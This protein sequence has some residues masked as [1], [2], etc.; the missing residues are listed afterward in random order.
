MTP[1]DSPTPHDRIA[2][3]VR[4]ALKA[5]DRER[6]ATLRLLLNEIDNERIRAG[7]PVDEDSFLR[8]VRRSVKQRE[9]SASQYDQG[10]RPELA[11]RER[12]EIE[13]LSG[14]L[15]AELDD[16]EL[17]AAIRGIIEDEGLAGPAGLG[18]VMKGMMQRYAGRVDGAR[19]NRLARELLAT[20]PSAAGQTAGD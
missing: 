1:S 10:G 16:A 12:R 18:A 14:Y 11:E 17:T 20:E 2:S 15:P 19:V 6:V 13:I 3:T 7:A 4:E 5:G 9:E 8:L